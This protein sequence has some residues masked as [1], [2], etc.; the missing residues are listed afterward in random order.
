MAT[1]LAKATHRPV[2]TVAERYKKNPGKGWGVVAKDLGIKPGSSE[3]HE[4]KR[5]AEQFLDDMHATATGKQKHER[6][7]KQEPDQKVKA[8]SQGK[9]HG[10]P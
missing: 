2:L 9:A 10:K 7:L 6:D 1:A 8:E 5:G 4:L 3:F